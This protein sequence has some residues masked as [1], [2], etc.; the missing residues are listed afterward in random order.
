MAANSNSEE[1]S[2]LG[3]VFAFI[4]I[5]A[6]G[7]MANDSNMSNGAS[8]VLVIIMAVIGYQVGKAVELAVFRVM[9]I[10]ASIIMFLT[11][12]AIRRFVWEMLSAIVS[13]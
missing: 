2:V 9:F 8:V 11:N 7:V 12:L 13:D 3:I 4:G 1:N 6:A 10:I 5:T